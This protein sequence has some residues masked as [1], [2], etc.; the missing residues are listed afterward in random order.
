MFGL[1]N[2]AQRN[3]M[4]AATIRQ[5]SLWEKRQDTVATLSGGE[6]QRV[7]LGIALI[8]SPPI[9]LLD[10]PTVGLDPQ[11]RANLWKHFRDLVDRGTTLILSSHVMDDARRCDRVGFLQFGRIIA[12]GTP[13]QLI[14]ATG[15]TDS[16]LDDAFLYF[17]NRATP[18]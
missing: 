9:L 1:S 16:S 15:R 8:H 14:E 6:R 2:R 10:E 13:S 17:M 7:S 4:I 11:L 3:E 12:E 18:Q 5:V